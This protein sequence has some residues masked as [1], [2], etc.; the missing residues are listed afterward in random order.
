MIYEKQGRQVYCLC[1]IQ[2]YGLFTSQVFDQLLYVTFNSMYTLY[3][4]FIQE[5]RAYLSVLFCP[6]F[7]VQLQAYLE[8]FISLIFQIPPLGAAATAAT[9]AGAS[10]SSSSSGAAARAGAPGGGRIN[11]SGMGGSDSSDEEEV[12]TKNIPACLNC[13]F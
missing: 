9:T 1:K 13:S 3:S 12:T 5:I 10:G 8:F 6:P 7:Y 2:S 4:I 11:F